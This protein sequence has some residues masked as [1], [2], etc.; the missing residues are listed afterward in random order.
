MTIYITKRTESNC[1]NQQK[2]TAAA[3]Q[4]SRLGRHLEKKK[5]KKKKKF[6]I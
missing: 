6:F 2:C 1:V 5:K 4:G 3:E